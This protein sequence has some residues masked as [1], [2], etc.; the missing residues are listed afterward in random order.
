MLLV[1]LRVDSLERLE[2]EFLLL[3]RDLRI[4]ND[5][6]DEVDERLVGLLLG[7]GRVLLLG[8]LL[9]EWLLHY[10]RNIYLVFIIIQL[11]IF[12]K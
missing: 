8:H 7:T 2:L 9:A 5:V 4:V 6:I 11:L 3:E 1:D 10:L 12:P